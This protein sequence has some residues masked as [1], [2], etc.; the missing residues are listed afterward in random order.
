MWICLKTFQKVVC[1]YLAVFVL[2]VV[3]HLTKIESQKQ[4]E[5]STEPFVKSF[6]NFFCKFLNPNNFSNL[7]SNLSN[8]LY[9]RNL[10]EHLKKH[11]V[12]KNCSTFH[13]LNK[14]L[15]ISQKFCKFSAFSLEFQTFL[16]H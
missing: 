3:R 15:L 13:C 11:S 1:F 16:D 8:L 5:R 7:D 4:Q 10:Q 12:T 9:I 2:A 6:S 14:L